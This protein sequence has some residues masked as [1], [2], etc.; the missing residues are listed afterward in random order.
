MAYDAKQLTPTVENR[1]IK[2]S[3]LKAAWGEKLYRIKLKT[4]NTKLKDK[5]KVVFKKI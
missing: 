2:D 4:N 1:K 3:K 5:I